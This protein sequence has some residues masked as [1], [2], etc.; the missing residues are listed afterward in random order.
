MRIWVTG[1]GG[2]VGSALCEALAMDGHELVRLVRRP[3]RSAGEA[4]WDPATGSVEPVDPPPDAVLHLAGENVA[5]GR[6]NASRRARIRASRVDASRLLVGTL[7]RC[8]PPRIHLQASAVG[9]YGDRGD[10]V[11]TE[12]SP[13]GEGFLAS[14]CRE[15]EAAASP[16]AE[17]GCRVA[18]LRFGMVLSRSGGALA[19]MLPAFRLGLGGPLGSG[20]QWLSWIGLE[21]VVRAVPFLLEHEV[22]GPVNLVSPH[23]VRQ[24]EFARALGAVLRRPALMP[25]PAPLLRLLL[26]DLANELLLSS[27]RAVPRALEDAGFRFAHPEIG[28]ALASLFERHAESRAAN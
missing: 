5:S 26:G 12:S 28:G 18:F 25:A 16:L 20:R 17:A 4:R 24:R 2:L 9:F 3:A 15:W 7:L 11:L 19:R 27:Q 1:S 6:W 23:P 13:P 21:D 22:H 10:E 8:G 14:V